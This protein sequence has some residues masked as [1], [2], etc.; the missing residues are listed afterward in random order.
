MMNKPSEV[1]FN[2]DPIAKFQQTTSFDDVLVVPQYSDILS[3]SE[4]C[5]DSELGQWEF[6]LPV[7]SSPMD[8]VTGEDMAVAMIEAGGLGIIHR[9][10][11]IDEQTQVVGNVFDKVFRDSPSGK[12]RRTPIACAIGATGDYL[13]RACALVD[14]GAYILCVDVAHGHHSIVKQALRK[15]RESF[16]DNVHIMAG[17]VATLEG[18]NALA[19]WG[20]HSVRVGIGGGS[21]CSTRIVT[22]HGIPTLQSI[23]DCSRSTFDTKIIADGGIRT[24]GDMVKAFAAGADFVMIGSMLAGTEQA[25]GEIFARTDGKKYKVYRGMASRAAQTE[26]RNKSSTPEGISTTI[27]YK[28]NVSM[29]LQDIRGGICSGLSY[30]GAR[31][32]VELRTRSQF[33]RQSASG[34]REGYTHI[35]SDRG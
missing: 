5:L 34:Q 17:N 1:F 6:T 14:H 33:V 35:L 15:L 11:S 32:L 18:F 3:R 4:V 20:A 8:T 7:V 29:V 21:I 31:N 27:P 10:N 9:Y 24:T 23:F 19:S 25:P 16:N 12:P 26:W 22:G 30:T 2:T 28:G 13:E